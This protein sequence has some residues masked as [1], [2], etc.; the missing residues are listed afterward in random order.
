MSPTAAPDRALA[1]LKINPF[2]DNI[3]YEPRNAERPIA[4]LNDAPLQRL[5][6][7]WE[8][9]ETE[10]VPRRDATHLKAQLVSSVEPGYGKSHLIGRL[11][12][13]LE[14]RATRIYVRPFQD[15]AASWR[16]ILRGLV[17]EISQPDSTASRALEDEE[18]PT[19]LDAFA[20]GVIAH[21]LAA[22]I[23][24]GRVKAEGG[25]E[26]ADILS[27]DPLRAWDHAQ[28]WLAHWESGEFPRVL[29]L[30][31]AE[32]ERAGLPFSSAAA[33][34]WLRV[35]FAYAQGERG[36]GQRALCLAWLRGEALAVEE[37][38]RLGLAPRDVP[39]AE[40][41]AGAR[42]EF[43]MRR[44]LDFCTLAGFHRPLL[45][46][47]DQ[48][49]VFTRDPALIAEFGNVVEA[50]A[51]HGRNLLAVVTT[52]LEPWAAAVLPHLQTAIRAR[53]SEPIQ[54][55]GI[56]QTQAAAFAGQ[57]LEARQVKPE[58]V[59]SFC[60]R[61][62]LDAFFAEKKSCSVRDFLGE[63]ARR[64]AELAKL[65]PP[66]PRTLEQHLAERRSALDAKELSFDANALQWAVGAETIGNALPGVA[67]EK[68]EDP[69]GYFP[70]S[71][72]GDGQRVFFGFEDSAHHIRWDAVLRA[73]EEVAK[74]HPATRACCL[75]TPEQPAVPGPG[76]QV[77]GERMKEAADSFSIRVLSQEEALLVFS[78]YAFWND[79]V[80]GDAPVSRESALKFLR[81]KLRPW[82]ESLLS[83][84]GRRNE[85]TAAATG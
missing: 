77:V 73:A 41:R 66:A 62:W 70:L 58:E 16:S 75:R 36:S 47:F 1:E 45:F 4:G 21:L 48:T 60:E 15:P 84:P 11:F 26:V 22:L 54:L 5:L 57:R 83:A 65:P 55:G 17:Q 8:R 71:W 81:E 25:E 69:H 27:R 2:E 61:A 50:L 40:D 13:T 56:D 43:A 72:R 18:A 52:N 35:L 64:F 63:C 24:Q 31:V 80:T 20:H 67:A 46:C 59:A 85:E 53:F 44:V 14:D 74:E 68:F 76:W 28:G 29:P 38:A 19:Q 12:Q 34:A 33:S 9:L 3:V 42:N 39:P 51:A 49:E 82:W 37:A 23:R 7:Q 79:V 32:L 6:A 78:A 30:C 10:A